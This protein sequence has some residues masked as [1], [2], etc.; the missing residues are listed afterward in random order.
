MIFAR[1]EIEYL[2]SMDG[3][4]KTDPA[5]VSDMW[6]RLDALRCFDQNIDQRDWQPHSSAPDSRSSR[7]TAES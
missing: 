2:S 3:R 7:Q 6:R 5:I 1:N 4:F